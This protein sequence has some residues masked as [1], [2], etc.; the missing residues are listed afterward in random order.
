MRERSSSHSLYPTSLLPGG[1]SIPSSPRSRSPSYSAYPG[2]PSGSAS[3]SQTRERSGS[4][5]PHPMQLQPGS[6]PSS[7]PHSPSLSYN[8]S[9]ELHFGDTPPSSSRQPSP[10]SSSHAA[11]PPAPSQTA[12]QL[13]SQPQGIENGVSAS[14]ERSPSASFPGGYVPYSAAAL[15][16][17]PPP[18]G[19]PAPA[20][21]PTYPQHSPALSFSNGYLNSLPPS[22]SVS[23]PR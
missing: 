22:L 19:A 18:A 21:A 1:N 20:P 10:T 12:E 7:R 14:R 8:G 5:S 3:Q 2:A 16:K 9:D 23:A 6:R 17:A 11:S 4:Y 13:A 15:Q